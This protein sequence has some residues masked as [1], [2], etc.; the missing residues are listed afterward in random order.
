MPEVGLSDSKGGIEMASQPDLFAQGINTATV[1]VSLVGGLVLWIMARFR[2]IEADHLVDYR[3]EKASSFA[4]LFWLTWWA[5][6][7]AA[8]RFVPTLA[9]DNQAYVLFILDIGDVMLLGFALCYCMGNETFRWSRLS[10]LPLI[11]LGLV[12]Y[13]LF[14]KGYVWGDG[15]KPQP[16]MSLWLAAPSAVLANIALVAFGWSMFVRWGATAFP[17]LIIAVLYA[18][19]QVPAY[20][21]AFVVA[22]FRDDKNQFQGLTLTSLMNVFRYLA[23][24]KFLISCYC[25]LLFANP[26]AHRPEMCAASYWPPEKLVSVHRYARRALLWGLTTVGAIILGAAANETVAKILERLSTLFQR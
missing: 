23:L 14:V 6:M 24:A 4:Y 25:F 18:L 16:L 20:V 21:A 8:Y 13:Y 15:S 26:R 7:F 11:L 12:L 17:L 9:V 2:V 1:L 3:K 22:P 19:A 10:P 5:S